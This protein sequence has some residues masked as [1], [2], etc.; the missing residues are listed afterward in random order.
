MS[1]QIG[2]VHL[3][4]HL[5]PAVALARR[6]HYGIVGDLAG[7]GQGDF[8]R[9]AA[10]RSDTAEFAWHPHPATRISQVT[11]L[12]LQGQGIKSLLQVYAG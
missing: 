6:C 3:A 5:A 7:S 2:P 10:E 8:E 12:L 1:L 9:P 11:A 4:Q